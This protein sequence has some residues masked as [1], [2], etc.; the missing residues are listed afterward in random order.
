MDTA[1]DEDMVLFGVVVVV[2]AVV[3][4]LLAICSV[5]LCYPLLAACC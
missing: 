4:R 3:A 5:L 1:F 2:A